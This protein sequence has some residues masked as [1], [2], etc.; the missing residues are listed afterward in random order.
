[1]VER[2]GELRTRE[3][4][5]GQLWRSDALVDIEHGLTKAISALRE[6]LG[7]SASS[8]RY[9]E[10][11]PVRGYRFIPVAQE[12]KKAVRRLRSRRKINFVAVLPLAN[13]SDDP[14]LELLNKRIVE[15]II[16]KISHNPEIRVLAYSSVQH[17][18]HKDLDLRTVGQNLPV[19]AVASGEIIR[20]NEELFLHME[21]I[22]MEDG[23]Q[24]WGDQLR[25]PCPDGISCAEKLADAICMRL[26]PILKL[27][28][29]GTG[30]GSVK[31][32]A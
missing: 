6:V 7:D 1:L 9:I 10:T 25:E 14:D 22:D 19:Q 8:P 30:N 20:R 26:R 29:D 18:H 27:N 15:R 16:D 12:P 31:R 24:L 5:L 4:L 21:L 11:I 17:H 32:A 23:T 2:P 3:E 13:D 28:A